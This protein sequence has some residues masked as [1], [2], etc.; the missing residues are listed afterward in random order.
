M[1]FVQPKTPISHHFRPSNLTNFRV[2][3]GNHYHYGDVD[4]GAQIAYSKA[5]Q[6]WNYPALFYDFLE[7]ANGTVSAHVLMLDTVVHS[8]SPSIAGTMRPSPTR[9]ST[10]T[11]PL[12]P[13][14]A[15][16]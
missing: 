16:S 1:A 11:R 8:C 4:V 12:T 13:R 10:S 5:S 6:R 2:L 3:A 9:L 14:T 15:P 7:H